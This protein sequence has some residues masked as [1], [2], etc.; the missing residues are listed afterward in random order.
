MIFN[1]DLGI[2]CFECKQY[3]SPYIEV[4]LNVFCEGSVSCEKG[5]ILG[6]EWDLVWEEYWK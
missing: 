3:Y 4:F 6:Y 1:Y 2:Y 5:H